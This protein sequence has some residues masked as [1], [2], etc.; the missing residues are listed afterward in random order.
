MYLQLNPGICSNNELTS[1]KQNRIFLGSTD[2]NIRNLAKSLLNFCHSISDNL[3]SNISYAKKDKDK[4][5]K[6]AQPRP[7]A[8][9]L[10]RLDTGEAKP[11]GCMIS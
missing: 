8:P 3:L 11:G 10:P 2:Q 9:P 6:P 1:S 7:E 4:D 5:K